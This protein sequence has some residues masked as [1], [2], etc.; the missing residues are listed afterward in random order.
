MA[1]LITLLYGRRS[2]DTM[3]QKPEAFRQPNCIYSLISSP[4][5]SSQSVEIVIGEKFNLK[6]PRAALQIKLKDST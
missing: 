6:V 4:A 2:S 1:L 3:P 5:R